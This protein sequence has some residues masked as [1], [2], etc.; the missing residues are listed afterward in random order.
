[1]TGAAERIMQMIS[2]DKVHAYISAWMEASG[3]TDRGLCPDPVNMRTM[4]VEF[5]VCRDRGDGCIEVLAYHGWTARKD[6]SGRYWSFRI[7][8]GGLSHDEHSMWE[9]HAQR[10]S[11]KNRAR[12][13]A[14]IE[15]KRNAK[16]R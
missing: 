5:T 11:A 3:E 16:H 8:P 12:A 4:P 15:R 9:P 13:E 1:M 10:F 2:D 7:K 14:S 6:S